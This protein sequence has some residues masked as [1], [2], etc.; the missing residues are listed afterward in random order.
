ME[1]NSNPCEGVKSERTYSTLSEMV[2]N[3]LLPEGRESEDNLLSDG[4]KFRKLNST[5]SEMV[6]N[7]L[8]SEGKNFNIHMKV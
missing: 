5:L 8:P 2:L 1:K 3:N 4:K 7:N 6:Q